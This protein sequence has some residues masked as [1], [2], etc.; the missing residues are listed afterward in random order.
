ML[1]RQI[2]EAASATTRS[3]ATLRGFLGLDKELAQLRELQEVQRERHE[4]QTSGILGGLAEQALAMKAAETNLRS[5]EQMAKRAAQGKG[6]SLADVS[7]IVA[8][9]QGEC[10]K[11]IHSFT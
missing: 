6:V 4:T 1:S 2:N 9:Y 11:S 3:E 5:V 7:A 8:R 10:S